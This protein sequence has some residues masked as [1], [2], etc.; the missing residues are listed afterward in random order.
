MGL[1]LRSHRGCGLWGLAIKLHPLPLVV[2]IF[3]LSRYVVGACDEALSAGMSVRA[4]GVSVD[5][6]ASVTSR[7]RDTITALVTG[8]TT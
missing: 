2:V 4:G 7:S 1:T 8:S 6:L 3:L 5:D